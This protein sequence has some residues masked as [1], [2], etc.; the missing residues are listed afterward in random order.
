M[1]SHGA[2][3]NRVPARPARKDHRR[4]SAAGR[5][6]RGIGRQDACVL[7]D[8][9]GLERYGIEGGSA[10]AALMR[11]GRFEELDR[12][13]GH[14]AA[15]R[16]E[17]LCRLSAQARLQLRRSVERLRDLGRRSRRAGVG[18][19]DAQRAPAGARRR[20]AFRDRLHDARG[21]ALRR[22]GHG[23]E[24][25]VPASQL[26]QAALALHGARA[27][28]TRCTAPRI[29]CRSI[30]DERE[31][32]T[33][34]PCSRPIASTRS[35]SPSSVRDA[36]D[37]VRPAYMGLIKQARRL[38]RPPVRPSEEARPL[39]RHADPLHR[40]TTATFWA[41]IGWA[42]KEMFYEEAQRVPF[43][44]Y[45][46]D[47]AADTT[48]GTVDERFV[49]AVDVVPTCSRRAGTARQRSP[50][51]GPLAVAAAA[52]RQGRATGATRCSPSSTTPSARPARS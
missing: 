25:V 1:F 38:A 14:S 11:A 30:R 19:A 16:G 36:P 9:D 24:A 51:R 6:P 50:R 17:Q 8:L 40:R 13:D 34:I 4:L 46:P 28:S 10:I 52:R 18:L 44:V 47:P 27:L 42:K 49:E 39:R 31:L 15:G 2:T 12:Y 22:R 45:D 5:H 32:S 20:G 43:I 33:S 7:P 21:P 35:R 41:T 29:A 3:W 26:R 37:I 48:R 23:R